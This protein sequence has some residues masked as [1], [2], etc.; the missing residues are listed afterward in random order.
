MRI[1]IVVATIVSKVV[2][3]MALQHFA[4]PSTMATKLDCSMDADQAS[5]I[6]VSRGQAPPSVTEASIAAAKDS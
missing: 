4:R 3:T 2:S 1:T 5:K 6:A